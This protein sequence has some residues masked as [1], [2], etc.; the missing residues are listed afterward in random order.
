[1]TEKNQRHG[2]RQNSVNRVEI[3]SFSSQKT[4]S[5]LKMADP[6]PNEGGT[7]G[8]RKFLLGALAIVLILAMSDVFGGTGNV[9]EVNA[10]KLSDASQPPKFASKFMGPSIKFL[11]CYS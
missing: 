8:D 11:Y 6:P 4:I 7:G 9:K 5:P 3:S 1:M 10:Q 2:P